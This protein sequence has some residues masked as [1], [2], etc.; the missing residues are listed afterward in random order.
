MAFKNNN[1]KAV[2]K[3][4]V[5]T[6]SILLTFSIIFQ[7]TIMTRLAALLGVSRGP[8]AVLYL[9]ITLSLSINFLLGKKLI[10]QDHKIRRITQ[11]ISFKEYKDNL[12]RKVKDM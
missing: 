6:L 3:L 2:Q 9:F 4:L 1:T 11:H 5:F 12:Y 8:D 7:E 10:E